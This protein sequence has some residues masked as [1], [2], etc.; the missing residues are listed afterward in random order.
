MAKF[1]FV[2]RGGGAVTSD[3][4]TAERSA[5]RD[6]W[7]TWV[8]ALASNNHIEPGVHASGRTLRGRAMLVDDAPYNE[9]RDMLTGT[10]VVLATDLAEATELARG[11]PAFDFDGSVEI[12]PVLE[13]PA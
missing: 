1:L 10:L 8:A 12:R 3:L 7:R 6:N 11:C 4:S 2:F 9:T 5:N 13:R